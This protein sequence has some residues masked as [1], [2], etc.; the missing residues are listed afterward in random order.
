M[1]KSSPSI[2]NSPDTGK[3]QVFRPIVPV[4]FPEIGHL[5]SPMTANN[6]DIME[7]HG[8]N[9]DFYYMIVYYD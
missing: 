3:S 8:H 5:N 6:L 1:I 7:A 2:L 9:D 4:L